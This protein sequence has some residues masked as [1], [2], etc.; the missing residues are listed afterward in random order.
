YSEVQEGLSTQQGKFSFTYYFYSDDESLSK[1]STTNN[2]GNVQTEYFYNEYDHLIKTIT[3]FSDKPNS[4]NEVVYEIE[5][6]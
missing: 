6:Y 5:Y 2:K 3:T 1:Q 4:R